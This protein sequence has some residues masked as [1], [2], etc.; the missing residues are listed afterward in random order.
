MSKS[1]EYADGVTGPEPQDAPNVYLPQA[2]APPAYDA[3]AD[4]AAAHGWQDVY[5]TTRA[6][7]AGHP[8]GAEGVRG[9]G[10]PPPAAHP[11]DGA[12]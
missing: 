6:G 3:Y 11:A 1:F 5:G 4:P 8:G 7:G 12:D 10:G 2:A 9:A